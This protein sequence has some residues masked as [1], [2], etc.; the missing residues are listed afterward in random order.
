MASATEVD[1]E[2]EKRRKRAE[3]FGMPLVEN[4]KAR[5]QSVKQALGSAKKSAGPAQTP[6][7]HA[8]LSFILDES[9]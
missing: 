4:P 7:V 1:E 9:H 8:S 3:R 5:T 2:L 6:E